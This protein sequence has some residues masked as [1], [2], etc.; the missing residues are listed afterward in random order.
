MLVYLYWPHESLYEGIDDSAKP[1][2]YDEMY[3]KMIASLPKL[4][5]FFSNDPKFKEQINANLTSELP[6]LLASNSFSQFSY[7][8][9]DFGPINDVISNISNDNRTKLSQVLTTVIQFLTD[10]NTALGN[11]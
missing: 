8:N 4:P 10:F 6:T 2:K 7:N 11:V 5:G 1:N 3:S 9:G